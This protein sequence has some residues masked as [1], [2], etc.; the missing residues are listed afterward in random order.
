MSSKKN[1]PPARPKADTT[2][3][4]VYSPDRLTD[5]PP[6]AGAQVIIVRF[7]RDGEQFADACTYFRTRGLPYRVVWI[8]G[9]GP[10]RGPAARDRAEENLRRALAVSLTGGEARHVRVYAERVRTLAVAG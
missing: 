6:P 9:D 2:A 10:T 7:T 5:D 8:D 3:H 4:V 1:G